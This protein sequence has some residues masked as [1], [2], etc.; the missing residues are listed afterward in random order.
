[1][2]RRLIP[3]G[4][5]LWAFIAQASAISLVAGL[6]SYWLLSYFASDGAVIIVTRQAQPASTTIPYKGTLSYSI[7]TKR[8]ASCAGYV[9]SNFQRDDVKGARESVVFSRMILATEIRPAFD[10]TVSIVLPDAVVPGRWT[11]S[12]T[13]TSRC[14]TYTQVDLIARFPIEVTQ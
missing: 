12:A 11:F 9:T 5:R 14:P 7:Q 6:I 8:V 10:A 4:R 3:Y 1:M 13:V 2:P